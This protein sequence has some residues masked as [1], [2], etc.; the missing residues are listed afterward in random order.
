[1]IW[2]LIGILALF[3]V[4]GLGRLLSQ[5]DP[6]TMA[7]MTKMTGG[8]ILAAAAI[9]FAL[10]GRI[11]IAL[12]FGGTAAMLLGLPDGVLGGR[13]PD[14]SAPP[15][16]N[17]GTMSH[18]EALKVLGLKRGAST[19]DIREAHKRL[20][21]QNHPDQGGSDYLASKVNRAKD[22]LLGKR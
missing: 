3:L 7:R 18:D 21:K 10:L 9:L 11:P 19:D 14:Q 16:P 2:L 6:A 13:K 17:N 12:I 5:G 8:V 20:I 22:V 4:L 1:M 15:T